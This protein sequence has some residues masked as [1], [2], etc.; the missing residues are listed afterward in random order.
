[1]AGLAD[2]KEGVES[3]P[4]L[5]VQIGAP[6]LRQLGFDIPP[7]AVPAP[8]LRLY[9]LLAVEHGDGAHSQ[10]NALIRRLV[11]FE[12]AV[13]T[14]DRDALHRSL[15]ASQEDVDAGRLSDAE[16]VL[17]SLRRARREDP[18]VGH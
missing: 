10:Y 17:Q 12:R 4:S 6:R 11:S 3:V 14:A 5:L 16:D 15:A 13:A 7:S 18:P 2:W 8:E 1:M 9:E